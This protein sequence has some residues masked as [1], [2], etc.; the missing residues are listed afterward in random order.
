M[1]G[2]LSNQGELNMTNPFQDEDREYLVVVNHEVQYSLWPSSL[3]IPAGWTAVGPKGKRQ[4]CLDWI[5]ANWT[6][7]RPK[8]LIDAMA[9]TS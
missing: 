3:D 9:K 5:N 1:N 2:F 8:S 6:D 7:M 4:E